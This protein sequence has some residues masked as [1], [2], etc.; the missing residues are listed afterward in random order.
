MTHSHF[1]IEE[2]VIKTLGI[3]QWASKGIY[4]PLKIIL[5]HSVVTLT[6]SH[7][8]Q[9]VS[10]QT[11]RPTH[12]HLCQQTHTTPRSG[13]L[14]KILSPLRPVWLSIC[15]SVTC[16]FCLSQV[17]SPQKLGLFWGT[18]RDLMTNL[19][20]A[21]QHCCSDFADVCDVFIFSHHLCLWNT[22]LYNRLSFALVWA[23]SSEA[24]KQPIDVLFHQV[25]GTKSG[26]FTLLRIKQ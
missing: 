5:P 13:R 9:T 14:E 22:P 10:Q 11:H 6:H 1:I 3:V 26:Y 12:K 23:I 19:L 20:F 17:F 8:L 25:S 16:V 7:T 18:K 4:F 21:V 2:F 15:S 24:T